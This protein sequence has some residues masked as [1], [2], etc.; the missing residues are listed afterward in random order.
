VISDRLIPPLQ[1]HETTTQQHNLSCQRLLFQLPT[2]L[3][4]FTNQEA[5]VETAGGTVIEAVNDLAG[6]Y[7]ALSKHLLDDGG[8]IRS[9]IRIFVGD[10]DIISLDKEK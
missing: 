1:H 10:E 6:Q 8:N 3:R 2:P 5:T 7:P 4:K 9:F